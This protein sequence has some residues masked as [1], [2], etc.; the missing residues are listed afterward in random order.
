MSG[1][2]L[3]DIDADIQRAE[4]ALTRLHQINDATPAGHPEKARRKQAW[5]EQADVLNRLNA[6]RKEASS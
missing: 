3:S 4:G 6:E 5:R 1:R 2:T